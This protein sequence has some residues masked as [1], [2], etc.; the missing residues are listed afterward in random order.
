MNAVNKMPYMKGITYVK[1]VWLLKPDIKLQ[2]QLSELKEVRA[3]AKKWF[4][5]ISHIPMETYD[6][7]FSDAYETAKELH[8][9]GT[10]EKFWKKHVEGK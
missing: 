6:Q 7:K 3:F 10:I 2:L 8:S 1:A 4:Q 9:S 5:Y